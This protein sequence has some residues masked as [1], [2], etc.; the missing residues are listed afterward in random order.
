M[1]AC[2]HNILSIVV[3]VVTFNGNLRAPSVDVDIV[4]V[5][6]NSNILEFSLS[7]HLLDLGELSSSIEMLC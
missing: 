5:E 4:N 6:E 3:L 1:N 7:T 2:I